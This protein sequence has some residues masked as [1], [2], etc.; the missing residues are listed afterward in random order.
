MAFFTASLTKSIKI[1]CTPDEISLPA[2]LSIVLDADI[3]LR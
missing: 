3:I 1:S 2:R